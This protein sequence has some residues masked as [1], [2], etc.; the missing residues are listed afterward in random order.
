MSNRETEIKMRTTGQKR[1]H[2]ER[3]KNTW[4]KWEGGGSCEKAET[5]GGAWLLGDSNNMETS[6][7]EEEQENTSESRHLE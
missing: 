2:T 1:C 6:E 7:V 4:E 5:G 3:R